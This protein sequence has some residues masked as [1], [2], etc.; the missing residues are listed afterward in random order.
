MLVEVLVFNQKGNKFGA[1]IFKLISKK[2]SCIYVSEKTIKKRGKYPKILLIES[3]KFKNI[4]T[5]DFI[6]VLGKITGF[7]NIDW[8][9]NAHSIIVDK[10]N[11]ENLELVKDLNSQVLVCGMS[12]RDTV[13][14][15]SNTL[16]NA[17]VSLNRNIKGIYSTIEEREILLD[18][19]ENNFELMAAGTILMLTD[20]DISNAYT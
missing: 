11:K 8:L 7:E 10:N 13:T 16:D 15:T 19:N 14:V 20:S 6:V 5:K 2:V 17:T 18:K 1:N 4:Q 9:N 3:E 12:V